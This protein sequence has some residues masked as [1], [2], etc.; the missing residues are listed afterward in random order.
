[1]P[2][3]LASQLASQAS[4]N[5]QILLDRSRTRGK[6]ASVESYLFANGRDASE[7]DLDSIF[8]LGRSGFEA[9]AT[10][11]PRLTIYEENLFSHHAR[12]VD[13]T[14]L[15]AEAVRE[16][17]MALEGCLQ[18]LGAYLLEGA[19]SKVLEWLVRRFRVNEFN[20]R[21]LVALFLPYHETQNW[22]KMLTILH[23]DKEPMFKF[24]VPHQKQAQKPTS[25]ADLVLPRKALVQAMLRNGDIARLV[26]RLLGEALKGHKDGSFS[27]GKFF[28]TLVAFWAATMHDFVLAHG[29]HGAKGMSEGTSALVFA[30]VI[31]PLSA[32][33]KFKQK[34][35]PKSGKGQKYDNVER[36]TILT[37]Y[38]LLATISSQAPCSLTPPA[39]KVIISS[40]VN[41]AAPG[42]GISAQQL[43]KTL[44]AFC[45]TQNELLDSEVSADMLDRMFAVPEFL[46]E[47]VTAFGSWDGA[48]KVLAPFSAI[49]V[50]RLNSTDTEQ[51]S[52]ALLILE[53]ILVS[54]LPPP[55]SFIRHVIS[56]L[57]RSSCRSSFIS[58]SVRSLLSIL[59][60][61]Y[62]EILQYVRDNLQGADH[63]EE[64]DLTKIDE[65]VSSL[66]L[67]TLSSKSP[68]K[69]RDA[70]LASSNAD[71]SVRLSGVRSLL[72]L[73]QTAD[74]DVDLKSISEAL[75]ARVVDSDI[76]VIEAL[77]DH[78]NGGNSNGGR[79]FFDVVIS[80]KDNATQ[81]LALVCGVLFPAP[82]HPGSLASDATKPPKR[83]V[84]RAHL[85]FIVNK[86]ASANP[87]WDSNWSND[88]FHRLIFP[89][90]LYSKP[91]GKTADAV[92]DILGKAKNSHAWI[93][94]CAEAISSVGEGEEDERLQTLNTILGGRIASNIRSSQNKDSDCMEVISKLT[95]PNSHV[96]LL[97]LLII[98]ELLKN[99]DATIHFATRIVDAFSRQKHFQQLPEMEEDELEDT[100]TTKLAAQ[101]VNKPNS[102]TTESL[103]CVA[104]LSDIAALQ[105][106]GTEMGVVNWVHPESKP[107][108]YASLLQQLY[109][110]ANTTMGFGS[111]RARIHVIR[112]LFAN[113]GGE[114]GVFL[115]SI[116]LRFCCKSDTED[117]DTSTLGTFALY[118]LAAFLQ[119]HAIT[120]PAGKA[121]VDFQILVPMVVI[122]LSSSVQEVRK[123]A[124]ECL[125][126]LT[127][128][129][130][131]ENNKRKKFDVVYA[132][133]RVYGNERAEAEL[134]YLSPDDLAA[135][136]S[137][138]SG[139]K[140]HFLA[141]GD[142]IGA[143]HA[144][145]L[146]ST[147]DNQ[148]K[149]SIKYRT[150]ILCYLLSHVNALDILPKPQI[151]L[152]RVITPC[153]VAAQQRSLS[154]AKS[155]STT[156]RKALPEI[157]AALLLLPFLYAVVATDQNGISDKRE[158]SG[159]G[160]KSS[161]V[162]NAAKLATKI[163]FGHPGIFDLDDAEY[164]GNKP[165]T[166]LCRMLAKSFGGDDTLAALRLVLF[167]C[168][169]K[170]WNSKSTGLKDQRIELVYVVIEAAVA[171]DSKGQVDDETVSVKSL[172]GRLLGSSINEQAYI[173]I[174][175]LDKC[176]KALG[177]IVEGEEL[178]LGPKL[179]KARVEPSQTD[180]AVELSTEERPGPFQR[181]AI[182]AEVLASL[183]V[184][185]VANSTTKSDHETLPHSFDLIT[186]LLESLSQI[187]RFHASGASINSS[188]SVEFICQNIMASIDGVAAGV[189]DPPNISPTPIR[190]DVLVEII[191]VSSNPQT[192]HQALLLIAGLARLAPESVLRNVMPVFTFMGVG[193]AA[194]AGGGPKAGIEIGGGMSML[195]RDDGY[196][197]G[198]V[199]KTVD[200]IVPVMVSSLKESHPSGGLD[201]YIGARDFLRVFTD[202]ANHIPRHRRT[203]F[204]SH[205]VTVLG[206]KDFLAPVCL[207]LI[208]KS[209]N[210][211]VRSQQYL[212]GAKSRGKGK[213]KD[214][215]A[216]S[217]LALPTAL[218][219]HFEPWLQ[220]LVLAEMLRES[221]RLLGWA[222]SPSDAEKTLLDDSSLEEHSV[223][224]AVVFR[225]R[226]QAIITFVGFAA[227]TFPASTTSKSDNN[228]DAMNDAQPPPQDSSNLSDVIS[229]LI[230]L[231]TKNVS[232]GSSEAKIEDIATSARLSLTRVLSVMSAV[233]FIDTVLLMLSNNDNLI[234][235]GALTLLSTRL[236]R[237][238]VSIRQG[239]VSVSI[240]KICG[241]VHKVL[242]F[243][244]PNHSTTPTTTTTITNSAFN[245]IR[246]IGSTLCSGEESAV[247]AL[248][249]LLVGA[250]D[251]KSNPEII[252]SAAIRALITL[253]SKLGP[254]LIPYLRD[255]VSRAVNVLREGSEGLTEDTVQLLHDL[256]TA[257]PTFWSTTELTHVIKLYL[258]HCRGG[259]TGKSPAVQVVSNFMRSI[260]KKAPSKVLVPTLCDIWRSLQI[261]PN[262]GALGG[263]F[264]LVKRSLRSAARPAIQENLR[265]LFN[266][267]LS[268]FGVV[269]DSRTELG[270][271]SATTISAFV[272]LVVKLNEPTFRPLFRRLYDWAFAGESD[273][274]TKIMFYRVYIGLVDY[275]K[276]LMNP[277]MAI[278]LPP[279]IEIL[280]SCTNITEMDDDNNL[281]LL[282]PPVFETLIKSLA[283]DDGSFWRDDKIAQLSPL[284][285]AQIPV[286]IKL[287]ISEAK[288]LLQECIVAG[289]E[290]VGDDSVLKAMNLDILM[291]TRSEDVKTRLFALTCTETLWRANGSKLLGFVAE[292][293]TFIAECCE[294]ENDLV[295]REALKLKDAVE[296]VAGSISGL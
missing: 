33:P 246:A 46:Q 194:M 80:T 62:P 205:L 173:I 174:T 224:P 232:G 270:T 123:A 285:I 113:L 144:E 210:K 34:A 233:D 172:L 169:T 152:L 228:T 268:A 79:S 190:L 271:A 182:L 121:V 138:L 148:E 47:I 49:L 231:S 108:P 188:S 64:F 76:G 272:E 134:Q 38:I 51:A 137:T 176:S 7:Y 118:H 140:D 215:D 81:Y 262:T 98:R 211:I 85:T 112:T 187:I 291:H 39:L 36:D 130:V 19:A 142:Y 184:T 128:L 265:P 99:S 53:T 229:I 186:H 212:L 8:A 280:E 12:N 73:L 201:L 206:P 88:V 133:D 284:I 122:A 213:E 105:P 147:D 24:L 253:P 274:N 41:A 63:I 65:L 244:Q 287:N 191:R 256:L 171:A 10:L 6:H 168:T 159:K 74:A 132:F 94:G 296:S 167:E 37:S 43:V 143:W 162:T 239:P 282:L 77:Y 2:T 199:Q 32:I 227:K 70:L 84:V 208:E 16:L 3:A 13:R 61:R 72:D 101:V 157:T 216:Q 95:D 283:C 96:R 202:A 42:T 97:A 183:S 257:I 221:E 264:D 289:A 67:G 254:R 241:I 160:W 135:Y 56:L 238:A 109:L 48:E 17:D 100:L 273:I 14:L 235:E 21:A 181:L 286:C 175:V 153:F 214:T 217:A 251:V 223:S 200:S 107:D 245:A 31:E 129:S 281:G 204:F 106:S 234:Q 294:D 166:L 150:H 189:R 295:T 219:H 102:R 93:A 9:L 58:A 69:L 30:A 240:S 192:L 226:A 178:T 218:L 127:V 66:S 59:H 249:P 57:L 22:G 116:W 103:L 54:A 115:S 90:L 185:S 164:K 120:P 266:I 15:A 86:L 225:R 117:E 259:S 87:N 230:A 161:S 177:E 124:V 236:P 155:V 263:Y 269:K 278:L 18:E 279:S 125:S 139:I 50:E 243:R 20:V 23:L 151:D 220:V 82:P 198:I 141:D 145:Q 25:Q 111:P 250:V 209:A 292:T 131:D 5:A 248:V 1:M 237:I 26:V 275:F 44:V 104:I 55:T 165:W 195:S 193:A 290:A 68:S 203:N 242:L 276:N 288:T 114:V 255:I 180:R 260:A 78:S 163:V 40:M 222:I 149:E 136:M 52:E 267:F 156:K 11:N 27:G 83:S 71:T 197:W 92:W 29:S 4:Q 154:T 258:N 110:F 179:K 75:S 91:R 60:Q 35:N 261:A 293:T 277:Y 45:G 146:A 196:G 28:R 126:T 247:T 119:A 170:I 252:V 207:F 158:K 89:Y